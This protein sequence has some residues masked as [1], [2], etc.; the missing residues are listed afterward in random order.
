MKYFILF[1]INTNY[2]NYYNKKNILYNILDAKFIYILLLLCFINIK[3]KVTC[4][5]Q[6]IIIY[7]CK[8]CRLITYLIQTFKLT[9]YT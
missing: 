9:F 5:T 8:L 1:K 4:P 3:C 7:A 6:P 2:Y